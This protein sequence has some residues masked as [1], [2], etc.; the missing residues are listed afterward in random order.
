M[1]LVFLIGM[2]AAGKS[3]W[4][5]QLAAAHNFEYIDLDTVIEIASGETIPD[6]FTEYGESAFRKKERELLEMIIASINEDAIIACG[7]GTPCF[8]D[9]MDKLLQNGTVIYLHAEIETLLSRLPAQDK[10]R[11]LLEQQEDV[12][13]YLGQLLHIRKPVFEKA[14]HILHVENLTLANFD[15]IISSCT[16]RQ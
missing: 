1:S 11:P 15:E 16:S 12:K 7:G 13:S 5:Q 8:Y 9:N 2:P 10:Q 4:A 3:Y 6:F 14:H